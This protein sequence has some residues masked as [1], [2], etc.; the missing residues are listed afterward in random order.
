[1]RSGP[2]KLVLRPRVDREQSDARGIGRAY[3]EE[4]GGLRSGQER[5]KRG[6]PRD[7]K[8]ASSW[9]GDS[10]QPVGMS[11]GR[12]LMYAFQ[13]DAAR[14]DRSY[15]SS[16]ASCTFAVCRCMHPPSYVNSNP[17]L[18]SLLQPSTVNPRLSGPAQISACAS[19]LR[20]GIWGGGACGCPRLWTEGVGYR[21]SE[22]DSEWGSE[23]VCVVRDSVCG[24][25]CTCR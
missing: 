4:Y 6:V 24:C 12:A 7:G 22:R 15:A 16:T 18:A 14:R 3:R 21:M 13:R 11:D 19:F 17:P 8:R 23:C 20:R 10:A 2:H 9:A 25:V 5:C 1:M